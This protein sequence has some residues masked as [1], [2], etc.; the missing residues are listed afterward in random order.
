[1]RIIL[2]LSGEIFHSQN[3]NCLNCIVQQIK[4]LYIKHQV[5]IVIGGGN[6][7]RGREHKEH[8]IIKD[9]AGMLATMLNTLKIFRNDLMQKKTKIIHKK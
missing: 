9:H 6:V 3:E 2:K 7:Y 4:N 5:G 1:M 8:Q